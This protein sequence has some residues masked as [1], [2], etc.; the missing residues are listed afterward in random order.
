MG[1]FILMKEKFKGLLNLHY[2]TNFYLATNYFLLKLTPFVCEHVFE[3]CELEWR[4]MEI[5]MLLAVFVT[6]KS[7]NSPTFIVFINTLFTFSKVA[8]IVLYWR[9]GPIHVFIFCLSWFLHF[10]FIPQPAYKGPKNIVYLRGGHLD[11][12][13]QRDPRITWL[14]CFYATWSPPCSD[15]EPVF[16]EISTKF[17]GLN[18]LKFAKFDCNLYPEVAQK[19]GVSTSPISKQLPTIVMFQ[20]GKEVRRRPFVSSGGTVHKFIFSFAN[21]VKDFDLNKIYYECSNNQ[22]EVKA[23]NGQKPD[24]TKKS[25]EVPEVPTEQEKK[26]N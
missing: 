22:I 18:N 11:N 6:V 15:L 24:E 3:T 8:N 10:V 13:I 16:A 5:L 19:H 2:I 1:Q 14:V 9:E 23:M 4:E 7:R 20:K 17:G 12:E 25:G 21:L 26:E